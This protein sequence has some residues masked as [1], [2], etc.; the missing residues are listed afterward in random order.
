MEP[1]GAVWFGEQQPCS[2][3]WGACVPALWWGGWVCSAQLEVL[4]LGLLRLPWGNQAVL[5]SQPAQGS[6]GSTGIASSL[7]G[8][9]CAGGL[10]CRTGGSCL[11][12][13]AGARQEG[14]SIGVQAATDLGGSKGV[15]DP[16][17]AEDPAGSCFCPRAL[18]GS[19]PLSGG[20]SSS[21]AFPPPAGRWPGDPKQSPRGPSRAM[22]GHPGPPRAPTETRAG[23]QR[24]GIHHTFISE[25]PSQNQPQH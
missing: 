10:G 14:P 5:V 12:G 11:S 1:P 24:V 8:H 21:R 23:A 20:S 17:G 7:A 16:S 4:S 25:Y 13:V 19:S 2:S 3:P 22:C 6:A 18:L 15:A 9:G